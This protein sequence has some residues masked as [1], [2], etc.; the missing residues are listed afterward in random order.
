MRPDL[1]GELG[2]LCYP[3]STRGGDSLER[4][5]WFLPGPGKSLTSCS[6]GSKVHMSRIEGIWACDLTGEPRK[7]RKGAA[8][9]CTLDAK[10]VRDREEPGGT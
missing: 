5:T 9:P 6:F 10:G 8:V 7:D 2:T 4:A 1:A 3:K